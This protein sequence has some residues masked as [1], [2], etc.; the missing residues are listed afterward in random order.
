MTGAGDKKTRGPTKLAEVHAR[1]PEEREVIILNSKGQPVG[2]NKDTC[3]KFSRFLG[4]VAKNPQF[5]PLNC[6]TWKYL[7]EGTFDKIWEYVLVCV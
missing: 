5:A 3:Q 1:R 2:P 6:V 4:T 7:P